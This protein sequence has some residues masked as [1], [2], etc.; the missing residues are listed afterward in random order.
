MKGWAKPPKL[1]TIEEEE[2][3]EEEEEE[4]EKEEE[5]A[6]AEVLTGARLKRRE[7]AVEA[8]AQAVPLRLEKS[9]ASVLDQRFDLRQSVR[10]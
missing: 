1:Y 8:E 2:D 10:Q 5:E 7:Q 3:D 6:D 9:N 4:E